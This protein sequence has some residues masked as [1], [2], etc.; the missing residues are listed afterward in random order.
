MYSFKALILFLATPLSVLA[1]VSTSQIP[2]LRNLRSARPVTALASP[3]REKTC[4]VNSHG[5]L[6]TDDSDYVIS[7]VEECNNGG[8]EYSMSTCQD[9]ND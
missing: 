6:T 9:D 1:T 5:D 4:L 7:A 3:Q 8:R 2:V